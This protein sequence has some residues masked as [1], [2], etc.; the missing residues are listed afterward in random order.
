MSAAASMV[1]PVRSEFRNATRVQEAITAPLERKLLLWLAAKTPEPI[2]VDHLT[3]LGFVA[4]ILASIF[5]ALSR[6]NK[7]YL[8]LATFFIAVNWLGDSLDGTLARYRNRLRPRYGF[9]VDH[10]ADTFGAVF[11]MSGLALSGFLHWQIA[12][13]MLVGF[14]VLSIESY[15]TTYTLGK[16]RM[17]YALFGPTEIRILLMIGNIALIFRPHAHLMGCEFLLFDVGGAVAIVGMIGM[18]VGA[19]ISHTARLY[20]EE[21]LS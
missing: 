9:Y 14:L 7:F 16:F 11:L 6:W 18:A 20:R 3:A 12:V 2:S 4:Q 19:T 10:M 15:L 21:R 1:K 13:G 17:S 8:L 5:Y